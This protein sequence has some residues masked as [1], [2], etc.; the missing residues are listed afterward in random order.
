MIVAK[1]NG[2]V[3]LYYNNSKKFNTNSGGVAVHGDIS[4][5]TDNY[6]IKFGTGEDLKLY[7]DGTHSYIQDASTG[8]IKLDTDNLY[9]RSASGNETLAT[10]NKDGAVELY[11][12]GNKKF[13]THQYGVD[14]DRKCLY[15]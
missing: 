11:H 14:I 12:N 15:R 10:F 4:L 9:I 2:A 1:P 8:G 3:E 5:G 6:K 7:H 13:S